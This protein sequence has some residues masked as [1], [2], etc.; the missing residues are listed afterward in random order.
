MS[1]TAFKKII[2]DNK[3]FL[4]NILIAIFGV[5]VLDIVL[6]MIWSHLSN[7]LWVL[8]Y[9]LSVYFVVMYQLYKYA[10]P[11]YD[12]NGDILDPGMDLKSPGF[13]EYHWDLLYLHVF[14]QFLTIFT[15]WGWAV[16]VLIPGY[17]L[18]LFIS[19][20][21]DR[22]GS[23]EEDNDSDPKKKNKA[24]KKKFKVMKPR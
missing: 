17:G 5:N 21:G 4:I 15:K 9:F 24:E 13:I 1:K 3:K 16:L 6:G 14:T 19:N 23:Q 22:S 2:K 20:L 11:K 8:G 18:Y 12:V 7:P 10:L